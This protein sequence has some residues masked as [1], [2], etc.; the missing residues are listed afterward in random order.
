[1]LTRRERRRPRMGNGI[2]LLSTGEDAYRA[3]IDSHPAG[4][5]LDPSLDAIL[6]GD[7]VGT[8]IVARIAEKA[9]AGVE[10][11]VLVDAL[12]RFRTPRRLLRMLRRCRGPH[13][14][15]HAV[16]AS[17]VFAGTPT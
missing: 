13:G 7:E 10:V 3:M 11:R 8:E 9:R 15:V 1:M 4:A 16:V 6:A 14:L 5:S 2:D 12:F 17:A